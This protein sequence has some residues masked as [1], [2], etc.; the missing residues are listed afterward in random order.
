M[1]VHSKLQDTY[2]YLKLHRSRLPRTRHP[3]PRVLKHSQPTPGGRTR[4]A[5]DAALLLRFKNVVSQTFP[6][7]R[8]SLRERDDGKSRVISK[9]KGKE[10]EALGPK[11]S[12]GN[13]RIEDEV[14]EKSRVQ[15]EDDEENF[16]ADVCHW[17]LLVIVSKNGYMD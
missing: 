3:L 16:G 6:Q 10:K 13:N 12:W 7:K 4:R 11:W 9:G 15:S 8:K 1:P 5:K 2:S 17:W 14:S